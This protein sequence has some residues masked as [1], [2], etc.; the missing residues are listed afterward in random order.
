MSM[1]GQLKF[2]TPD[3]VATVPAYISG[4]TAAF[5][6]LLPAD[7]E[8][9]GSQVKVRGG[10]F[11][12]VPTYN[13]L[14]SLTEVTVKAAAASAEVIVTYE[15]STTETFVFCVAGTV[16]V[17]PALLYKGF[18]WFLVPV[19]PVMVWTFGYKFGNWKT[20]RR[21]RKFFTRVAEATTRALA[22]PQRSAEK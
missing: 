12:W 19:W 3:P 10:V 22:A 5:Y 9:I 15:I 8:V 21:M 13:L 4:L 6:E 2:A 14:S 1:H 20:E 7:L 11:R 16:F 17:I 18:P